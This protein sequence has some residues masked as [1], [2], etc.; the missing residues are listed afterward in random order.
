MVPHVFR[1]FITDAPSGYRLVRFCAME[2]LSRPAVIVADMLVD[3]ITG[4]LANP[5]S[6]A[7]IAPLAA[8]LHG[9]RERGWPICYVNDTHLLGDAEE[10]LWGPH[11]LAGT[12]GAQ[13]IPELTPEPR[14][15]EFGKRYCSGFHQTGLDVYL[16]Q[17]SVE[18]V[19][20]TGQH[21]HICVQHTAGDAFIAGHRVVLATDGITAFTPEDNA[22]GLA[23]AEQ[24]YGAL[25]LTNAEILASLATLET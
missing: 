24:I 10:Q 8:L 1:R 4:A 15:V 23:N 17:R 5:P 21:A 3:F 13:V 6:E 18:T 25:P 14:D 19:I 16:R 22:T 2:P 20:V 7:I 12:P 9:A 11:A